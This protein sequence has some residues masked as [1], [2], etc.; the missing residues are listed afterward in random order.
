[1]E[2]NNNSENNNTEKR[3]KLPE[4]SNAARRIRML[5]EDSAAGTDE[6]NC[7]PL[8]I[9]KLSNFWYH[10]KYKIIITLAFA[11][12]I[13]TA[14]IQFANRSN[15]DVSLLYAG[16]VYI[17][18]NE[19]KKFCSA[20]ESIMEDYNGDG[21]K[22]VQLNDLIFMTEGQM[23]K[24]LDEAEENDDEVV[25]DRLSNSQVSER[26]TY[27]V[28]GGEASIC[29]LAKDQYE[30]V[31]A[32][33]G[34]MKLTDIFTDNNIPDTAIDEYGLRVHDMKFYKFFADDEMFPED[35]VIALRTLSTMSALTG[36][37]KAERLHDYSKSLF[38]KL[39]EFEYPEGY[40]EN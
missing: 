32:E 3:D 7:E 13:G 19:N 33:G 18:P 2:E 12:I 21:K 22:Y 36:R 1:M 27:E 9:N 31:R 29:I 10:N 4:E 24:I 26:F 38:I 8:K 5:G 11:F 17:T 35:A 37:K 20:I 34:F 15:P 39:A 6:N 16:P 30:T 25:I 28:F 23:E 40:S 14:S